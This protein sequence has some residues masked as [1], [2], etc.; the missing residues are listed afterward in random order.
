M[1]YN[2]PQQRPRCRIATVDSMVGCYRHPGRVPRPP[3]L[4][5]RY[6]Y[7]LSPSASIRSRV[8]R[9]LALS[10]ASLWI[11]LNVVERCYR[12]PGGKKKERMSARLE[13]RSKARPPQGLRALE[14]LQGESDRV[15]ASCD[16]DLAING[17]FVILLNKAIFVRVTRP[18]ASTVV[19]RSSGSLDFP[20]AVLVLMTPRAFVIA[21]GLLT[22]QSGYREIRNRYTLFRCTIEECSYLRGTVLFTNVPAFRDSKKLG[23]SR[24]GSRRHLF[25][26]RRH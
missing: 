1:R 2:Q 12:R 9:E 24:F 19:S 14:K 18:R 16:Q 25:L 6:R 21:A 8:S 4:P 13:M 22:N 7:L 23:C 20:S 3:P 5:P 17:A 26:A 10:I 15:P 11:S